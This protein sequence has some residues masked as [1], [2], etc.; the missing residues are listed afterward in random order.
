LMTSSN[1]VGAC[2]GRSAGLAPRNIRL[3]DQ[4]NVGRAGARCGC[5]V[6]AEGFHAKFLLW[7]EH[8]AV[9]TNISWCSWTSPR[10]RLWAKWHSPSY[11]NSALACPT[12]VDCLALTL[13]G[14]RNIA[15]SGPLNTDQPIKEPC[16]GTVVLSSSASPLIVSMSGA[17]SGIPRS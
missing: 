3:R 16:E 7:G 8:E 15:V 14:C 11:R 5:Y 12:A 2:T 13:I 1:L 6:S 10:T 9:V 17:S 4:P